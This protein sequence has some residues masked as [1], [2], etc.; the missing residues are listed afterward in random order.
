MGAVT[1]LP[2]GRALT[3]GDLEQVPDD[4]HRYELIDGTLLVTPAPRRGTR[5]HR[6]D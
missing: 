4:G 6:C 5:Q 3:R 2:R 1:A